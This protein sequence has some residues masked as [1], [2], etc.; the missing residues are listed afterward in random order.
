MQLRF[1][2]MFSVTSLAGAFSGLLAFGIRN[3]NGKY[4]VAGWRWIFIL[5]RHLPCW[6]LVT[7]AYVTQ[8]G[9]FS[10]VFGFATLFFVPAS[11]K[12]IKFLTE[13]ERQTYCRDLAYDWSGD[14]DTLGTY[15]EKFSWSEVASVF[16]DAPHVLMLF[17]P[18]FFN[19]TTVR[20][21][22][23]VAFIQALMDCSLDLWS[24]QLVLFL[25]SSPISLSH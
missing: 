21:R 19:G 13:E 10:V 2:M 25:V 12:T 9:A 15:Q 5:V 18:F 16:T 22:A 1:A 7:S 3:L 17:L 8:E 24:R 6:I 11:P 23:V 20:G 4:G 14:A